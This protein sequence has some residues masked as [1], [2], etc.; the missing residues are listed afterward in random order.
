MEEIISYKYLREIHQ[1]EKNSPLICKIDD[2]FYQRLKEYFENLEDE[3]SSIEDKSSPKA[4]L[5][6]DEIENAKR[7]AESIYEQR[8]KKIV[9]AALVERKGGRPNIDNLTSSE[10]KLFELI[11]RDLEEGYKSIF[12]SKN[13]TERDTERKKEDKEENILVKINQDIPEFVDSDGNKYNL[14]KEDIVT[15]PK[16]IANALINRK[17]AEKEGIG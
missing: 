13:S 4:K 9:Q 14:K 15:L 17:V 10:K 1:K 5:L 6:R 3:Y 11:T 7:I 16:E 2:D 8:E 12:C